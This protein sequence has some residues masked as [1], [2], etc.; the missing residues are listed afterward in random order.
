MN[1]DI[2][3]FDDVASVIAAIVDE[4]LRADLSHGVALTGGRVGSQVSLAVV[5]ALD[6]MLRDSVSNDSAANFTPS[7]RL[8]FSDERFLSALH[9]DRNDTALVQHTQGRSSV[10]VESALGPDSGVDAATSAMDY[11]SRLSAAGLPKVAIISVGPDGHVASIFPGHRLMT[12]TQSHVE[13]VTDSP[14]PPPVRITWTLPMLRAVPRRLLLGFG[15]DKTDAI[16]R[17][18]AGDTALPATH[19]LGAGATLFVGR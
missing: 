8:W 6:A 14:K 3:E 7:V 2:R 1:T 11:E 10:V 19:V 4:T 16:T 18:I 5:D 12:A 15:D 9:Q 17:V 13:P